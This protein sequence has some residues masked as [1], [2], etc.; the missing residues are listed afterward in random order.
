M[1]LTEPAIPTA[2]DNFR[3]PTLRKS[4][5]TTK[6]RKPN[7]YDYRMQVSAKSAWESRI[8][9]RTHEISSREEGRHPTHPEADLFVGALVEQVSL[10]D[11]ALKDLYLSPKDATLGVLS[12]S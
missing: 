4:S 2:V 6:T 11:K 12:S 9:G 3:L 5:H 7:S 10:I 1:A 8:R